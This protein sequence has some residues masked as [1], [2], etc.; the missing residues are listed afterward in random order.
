M[1]AL[2]EFLVRKPFVIIIVIAL[3]SAVLSCS[4]KNRSDDHLYCRLNADPSTLDPA[5]ITDVQAS[6]VAAKLFNGLVRL[7][8]RLAVVPDIA[9]SWEMS[10]DGLIYRFILKK[11]VLFSNGREVTSVDFK[12]AFERVLDPR[13]RSP[14]KWIFENVEGAASFR[15][16]KAA[17]VAGFRAASPHEF[18]IRLS[19][20]FSPFLKMLAMTPAYVLPMEA[21]MSMGSEFGSAPVGTGPYILEA[22]KL[23]R[24]LLLKKNDRYFGNTPHLKGMVFRI[25]PEDL[26][27]VVEFELGN[28]DLMQLPVSAYRKMTKDSGWKSYIEFAPGLNTYYLGLNTARPPLNNR[29]LRKAITLAVDRRKMLETFYQG[30]G[31]LARG[32]VPDMLRNW[33]LRKEASEISY[34]PEAARKIVTENGL[35]GTRLSLYVPADQE[36]VDIA[37]IIQ[38]Y[39]SEAGLVTVVRQLEWSA[40][41][42]AVNKGEPDMFWLSWWADYPDPEN[43][44]FPLFHSENLGPAGNRTRYINGEVDRLIEHGR[45]SVDEIKRNTSYQKAE[46]IIVSDAPWVFFWHK[47]DCI[48]RQPWVEG[49][50]TYTVYNMDKG[51]DI[52]LG[53]RNN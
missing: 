53:R 25:I 4:A 45:L 43:F 11:G 46:E 26:T 31:R 13:T 22:W 12:Y 48:I 35:R 16:G 19:R 27:A 9:D 36:A 28:L 42:E 10:K 44:L 14:N 5:L 30:R 40:F 17:G 29:A 23:N 37:E 34:N 18:E 52:K 1:H 51:L 49:F 3:F 21:V 38:G 24:E 41:K 15:E 8:E 2:S 7:D 32:P 39:L 33:E 6:V 47:T 20:P 50:R